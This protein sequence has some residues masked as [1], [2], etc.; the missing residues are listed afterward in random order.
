MDQPIATYS[1][2]PYL[3]Q[4][5][6]GHII[7][8]DGDDTVKVRA[9]AHVSLTL[10]GEGIGAVP[11]LPV[12]KDVAIYGPGEIVGIDPRVIVRTAPREWIT[13][14]EPNYMPFIEFYEEDFPWRYT[15]AAADTT[16]HRLRPWIALVVL[17][18]GEFDEQ[19]MIPSRP[20]P[21]IKAANAA[22]LFPPADQLWAWAH[23]H[24]NQALSNEFTTNAMEPVLANLQTLLDKHPDR[25][26]AR[27]ICPRLL[28]E[29]TPYHAFL[30]PVFERGRLAGLGKNPDNAPFAT[31]S[32]WVAYPAGAAT[33]EEGDNYPYYHRWYFRTGSVGS[34]EY[35]VRLLVPRPMPSQVGN[36]PVD[37]LDPGADLPPI[38][39]PDLN[40]TLRLGGALQPPEDTLPPAEKVIAKKFDEWAIDY[41]HPF[42]S[43][44]AGFINLADEYTRTLPGDANQ[45]NELPDEIQNDPDPLITPPL[46]GRWHAP[47]ERLLTDRA[48]GDLP[49]NAN[50]V[51]DLNLDPRF[52]IAAGFGTRVVQKNQ[53]AYMDA[54][55]GQIGQVLEANRVIRQGQFAR[56]VNLVWYNA[57]LLPL[58][59]ARPEKALALTA[60]LHSRVLDAGLT[61]R[62]QVDL[63]LLPRAAVTPTARRILRPRARLVASLPF[64][65]VRPAEALVARLNAGEVAAAPPK[66]FPPGAATVQ[67]VADRLQ[68]AGAP[69]FV[70]DWL[71]RFPWVKYLPFALILIVLLLMALFPVA[72]LLALGAALV[73]GL[74]WLAR[75]LFQWSAALEQSAAVDEGEQTPEA[76]DALPKSPDFV[77]TYPG[78]PFTNHGGA[79]DSPEA[80]RYKTAL[81]DANLIDAASNAAAA[82]PE[83][84]PLDLSAINR[85][86][87]AGIDPKITITRRV[88]SSIFLPPRLVELLGGGLEE[89]IDYPVIDL[90][91]YDPLV[92]VSSELFLPNIN[93]IPQ[94]TLSLLE[95]NQ[96]FIEAYMV[97]LNHEFSR[98]L[99]W[100]EFPSRQNG[101]FF[102]Q[103]WD[104]KG[105]LDDKGLAD[106]DL[107]ES[108]YDIPPMTWWPPSSDLGRHNHR[109][110][111]GEQQKK[112]L[113]L[114]VRG[115]LLKKYPTAV[116]YAHAAEWQKTNDVMDPSKERILVELEGDELEKPPRTKVKT[117]IYEARVAPDIY[118]FGFDLD[119]IT[120]RGG[121]GADPNDP[122]GWF[123]VIKERPGEP[124]FGLDETPSD[125]I[126]VWNDL[127][128]TDVLP[129]PPPDPAYLQITGAL[130]PIGL[131]PSPADEVTEEKDQRPEDLQVRWDNKM[132]A[133]DLAYILYQA[134]VMVAVHAAEML[135]KD[136]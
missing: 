115:E 43:S 121:T 119:A 78:E 13:N 98:E 37:T 92:G 136:A 83:R 47:A 81:K 44:L 54:A 8:A 24:V 107:R 127:A 106:V 95:P 132:S 96:R 70:R 27:L 4:G 133:A 67:D 65:A 14:F 61:V 88:R 71:R 90:P 74:G 33:R 36:R 110:T 120:A 51:H 117:P 19:A 3:R 73:A 134:P 58:L 105:Y 84:R 91:M 45:A 26:Y 10:S 116:V 103:F 109:K 22:D 128:W 17:A 89:I 122:A 56:E 18:E 79:S 6:A 32:A 93:L 72:G 135:P 123:F 50:W 87:L 130:A 11:P 125:V 94:N 75:L 111:P 20:L 101:T 48:G 62:R 80:V 9:A 129:S 28:K 82:L 102:R 41:P 97:G 34:F 63:S 49:N 15:P 57:H 77:I 108:L 5:L 16:S 1:F 100:R 40:G 59:T 60:P 12:D 66:T 35:L 104:I 31:H 68:P 38:D 112:D 53:E 69:A 42:Q 25:A 126:S 46:Y 118:F 76:V 39:E 113:V 99:L 85:A 29:N 114:V 52:R 7:S 21:F 131:K 23:V 30:M 64:D 55:W 86:V 2:L 124:R